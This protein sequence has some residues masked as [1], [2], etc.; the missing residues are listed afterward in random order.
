MTLLIA[1]LLLQP[2]AGRSIALA[3]YARAEDA[4]AI[5]AGLKS[6]DALLQRAAL[7]A[8]GRLERAA[9]AKDIEP[10]V[11]AKDRE[12][13]AALAQMSAPFAFNRLLETER[14]PTVRGTIYEA[15]G[16]ARP[17]ADGTEPILVRGLAETEVAARIGAAPDGT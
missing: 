7:R 9:L 11:A 13:I 16:R 2:A 3:E 12:A 10:L 17:P 5:V 1:L 8:A 15:V 14:D 6:S 4:S